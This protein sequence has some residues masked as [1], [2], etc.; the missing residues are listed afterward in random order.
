MKLPPHIFLDERN[1]PYEARSFSP[2]TE[3]GAVNVARALG[4]S[5]R[6]AVKTLIF[7]VDT[8]ERVLVMLGG[9]QN[10]ISGNLKKAI[11]SRNI[12][13]ASPDAVK[14]TTGYVIGSIP[15]FGWQPSGFRSFLEATLLDEPILGTGAGQWGEEIMITPQN[16]VKASSAIVVNLT[17]RG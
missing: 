7:Q 9:D 10:A 17:E 2:E 1:I 11:G 13:M 12:Q 4:F 15:A 6:Q 3:K 5:E 8:G 16:L 14:E